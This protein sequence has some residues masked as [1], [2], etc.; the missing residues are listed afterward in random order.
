MIDKNGGQCSREDLL[1]KDF[2]DVAVNT[3]LTTYDEN[4][5]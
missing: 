3:R 2:T 5:I 4:D 1:I